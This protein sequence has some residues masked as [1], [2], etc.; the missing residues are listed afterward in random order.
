LSSSSFELLPQPSDKPAAFSSLNSAAAAD[1][2]KHCSDSTSASS[3]TCSSK[4]TCASFSLSSSAVDG[5][6]TG[7]S[8]H[9]GA[10]RAPPRPRHAHNKVVRSA[11]LRQP[12]LE[13]TGDVGPTAGPQ[14]PLSAAA[15][16]VASLRDRFEA[17]RAAQLPDNSGTVSPPPGT[18]VINNDFDFNL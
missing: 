9:E 8:V 4:T 11:S 2:G 10:L 17:R 6:G 15:S 16:V 3:S 12:R 1:P 7:G 5:T 13:H 18:T 14:V